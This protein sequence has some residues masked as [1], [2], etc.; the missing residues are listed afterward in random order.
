[1]LLF[2]CDDAVRGAF[3]EEFRDE[4]RDPLRDLDG[5]A[6]DD[7][8]DAVFIFTLPCRPCEKKRARA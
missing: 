1:L 8:N 4:L 2:R 3:C 6:S 5:M 7:Y